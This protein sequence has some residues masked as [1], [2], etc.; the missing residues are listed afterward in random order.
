MKLP[1]D[2]PRASEEVVVSGEAA[3]IF[4]PYVPD[5][6]WDQPRKILYIGKATDGDFTDEDVTEQ[7]FKHK[8][9]HFWSFADEVSALA[10]QNVQGRHNL[11]WSNIFKQGVR[12]GNPLG[13]KAKGQRVKASQDLRN[14]IGKYKPDLIVLVTVGYEEEVVKAAFDINDGESSGDSDGKLY[15]DKIDGSLYSVW[16]RRAYRSVPP[17]VWM[18]HPQGKS[19]AYKD[20]ALKRITLLM[21]W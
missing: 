2:M 18:N 1:S 10:D 4:S 20:A 12:R 5:G 13:A 9:T 3:G 19:R 16:W 11:V 21:G 17:L 14:E 15:E 6:Y 8:R 7:A